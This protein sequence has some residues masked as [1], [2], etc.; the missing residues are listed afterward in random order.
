MG[1][2]RELR[3]NTRSMAENENAENA[4]DLPPPPPGGGPSGGGGAG[5]GNV[6]AGAGVAGPEGVQGQ[7]APD[8]T[9]LIQAIAGAFHEAVAGAHGAAHQDDA[10]V[11]LP[12]ERLRSLGGA[13]FRGL[14]L[15]GSESWLESTKR[16]LGQLNCNNV[17]KL[18]CIVSLLHGDAYTWWTTTMSRM[19]DDEVTWTFFLSAFKRKYLGV[20]YLDEKK[21]EFMS[22]VQGNMSVAEYEIQFVRLSQYAPELIPSERERCERF[23]Y[24]LVA[25]VKTYMLATDY[26][27]FNVLVTRAKDIESNLGLASRA[28]GSS[29]GKRAAERDYGRDC[30]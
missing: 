19:E 4:E 9:M 2:R 8:M 21:R 14:S 16:I 23:R 10:N 7:A 28:G 17:Q 15:E 27:Y 18:G 11:R 12:L 22:V 13:E 30:N 29:S 1:P 26:T 24:G 25:D 6:G 20:R 3:I 5:A